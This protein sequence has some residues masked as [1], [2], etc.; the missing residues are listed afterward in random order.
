LVSGKLRAVL[1]WHQG[2]EKMGIGHQSSTIL[3]MVLVEKAQAIPGK[4]QGV[5]KHITAKRNL[6]HDC[7]D[8]F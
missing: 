1:R 5:S 2:T 3:E 7:R 4:Y 8:L 6:P